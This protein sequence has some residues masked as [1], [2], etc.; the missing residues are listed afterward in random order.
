M[1]ITSANAII[2]LTAVG[3]FD[4]PFQLQQFEVDDLFGVDPIEVAEVK[5]SPDGFLTGGFINVPTKQTFGLMAD[6]PSN[7]FFE[8]IVLQQKAN[9]ETI[10]VNGVILLTAVSKKWVMT[11][12]FITRYAPMPD[13]K[14]TLQARKHEITWQNAL[15]QA[16]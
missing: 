6:S 1:S 3:V 10:V 12:G 9:Q 11:R 14:K 15:P 13:A 7:F 2:T 4:A 8:Q 16:A 5:M